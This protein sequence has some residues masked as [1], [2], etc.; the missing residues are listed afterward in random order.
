[1]TP[2]VVVD[3][4]A[5]IAQTE[6]ALR[7]LSVEWER[8]FAGERRTPPQPQRVALQR[9]LQMLAERASRAAD[10]FR[11]EQLQSRFMSYTM[12]WER[13]L[14]GRE[15][16]NLPTAA[17]VR[18][19]PASAARGRADASRPG[20]VH[21]EDGDAIWNRFKEAKAK[22]GQSTTI[23]RDAF[24]AQL[25]AQRERLQA[26]LGGRVRFDVVVEDGKVRLAARKAGH[27]GHQ[28]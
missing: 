24:L 4:Q 11:I 25:E 13:Q 21:A 14:R 12:M 20:S 17:V 27:G 26:K 22:L 15:E 8:F 7:D 28:E 9:R 10:Q 23:Q 1:V 3:L 18:P 5:A 19:T 16:G 2:G 6:Q